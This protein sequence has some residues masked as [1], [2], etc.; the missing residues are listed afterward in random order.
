MLK[1]SSG[2]IYQAEESMVAIK[3]HLVCYR[4]ATGVFVLFLLA[5]V[6]CDRGTKLVQVTGAIAV[7]GQPAEGAVILFYAES[8]EIT[9]ISSAVAKPDG[10]FAPV[11][12]SEPGLPVGRYR[13][14]VQWPDPSVKPT[15]REIMLGTD[16]TGEDLL[17]GRFVSKDKS[18]LTAE[19]TS[20][21]TSLPPIE[22]SAK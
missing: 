10:T 16:K 6:G 3:S 21:T 11:T 18:K 19:V 12:D 20:T 14:S 13:L 22:L 2:K 9:S 1:I 5:L 17:Q 8:P 4:S 15:E 7:D